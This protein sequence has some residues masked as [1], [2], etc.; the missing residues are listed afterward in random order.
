M[1]RLN[2]SRTCF[3]CD[4]RLQRVLLPSP[5]PEDPD[6]TIAVCPTCDMTTG[7]L[8]DRLDHH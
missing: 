6:Y 3:L 7:K 4:R 1:I 8:G 2:R 5:K